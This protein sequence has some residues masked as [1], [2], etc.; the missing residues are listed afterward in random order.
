[1]NDTVI[2]DEKLGKRYRVGQATGY[3]TL[4]D[5]LANMFTSHFRKTRRDGA[6]AK[7]E[8]PDKYIW[9][10]RD[11]SFEVKRGEALGIIGG[12]GAGKTTLLRLLTR[13]AEPTEGG[14]TGPG[15]LATGGRDWFSSRAYRK[16]K[17]LPQW[18]YPG[19]EKPGDQT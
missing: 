17:C 7:H 14:D 12:N 18:G 8:T 15:R 9:A 16:R 13:I 10:L 5:A 2:K 6:T 3:G 11:V 1:M 4:R 19:H